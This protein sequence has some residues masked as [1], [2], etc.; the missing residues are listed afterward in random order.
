[1]L[2]T[3]DWLRRC[4]SGA[5]L[6]ATLEYYMTA[7]DLFSET[8]EIAPPFNLFSKP[9]QRCWIY[10]CMKNGSDKDDKGFLSDE[11]FFLTKN[12]CK[13]CSAIMIRAKK[14][15]KN[16]RIAVVIWGFINHLP[17]HLKQCEGFYSDNIFGSYVH[18]ENHFL[19]MMERRK[20]KNWLQEVL[21]YHGSDLKGLIQ[22]FPTTGEGNI[23]GMG[24]ILCRA[25]HHENRYPMD[26]LRVRFFSEPYQ[27][28]APHSREDKGLLTF[29]VS[30][31]L[32]LLE[33]TTVFRSLLGPKEQ[34]MLYE[35]IQ[36]KNIREEQFYWG[37]FMGYLS[38]QAKD[39][40][41][42]WKIRQ[43]DK[44]RIRLLYELVEYTEYNSEQ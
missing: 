24:E 34:E 39:M 35:L 33:M 18:D 42:L 40:L 19:L 8:D 41:N 23:S 9:C 44:Q 11:E 2:N 17:N 26:M 37:R 16:S 20:L 12:Y 27:L 6:L 29:E 13:T 15:G 32:R 31:F 7:P 43:W 28:L 38:G 25:V 30:E 21:I 4:R 10:P 36:L 14:R 22:I 1:M 3:F 5:E